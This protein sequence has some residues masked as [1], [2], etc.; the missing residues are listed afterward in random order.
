MKSVGQSGREPLQFEYP[1]GTAVH[2]S[3]RVSVADTGNHR[4]QVLNP[5]LSYSH[6]IGSFGSAPG[7]FKCPHNMAIDSSGVVYVTDFGNDRVQLLSDGQFSSTFSHSGSQY[8]PTGICIDS[9]NT[10]YITDN[11]HGVSVYT[12]SG[13]FMKCFGTYGSGEGKFDHPE[14]VAVDNTTGALYVCDYNNDRVVVY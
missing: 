5:D 9:T 2:A 4:I 12:S 13:Q 6:T 8:F 11:K 7:Q 10:V 3:G 14:G 1:Y